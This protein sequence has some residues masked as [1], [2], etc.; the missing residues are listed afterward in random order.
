MKILV[1]EDDPMVAHINIKFANKAGYNDVESVADIE[2]AKKRLSMGDIDLVLLDIYFPVGKGTEILIW[3]RNNRLNTDVILITADR[4][5][6]T[7]EIAM[8]YGAVDYLI[9]PFDFE[10]FKAAMDKYI[11]K[12]NGIS[13]KINVEQNDIDAL[14]QDNTKKEI[15]TLAGDFLEKGMSE[16]TYTTIYKA[17][18]KSENAVTSEELGD[19]LGI[20]RVSVRRYLEFMESKG[21]LELKLIY[22]KKGRPQHLF[23]YIEKSN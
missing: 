15:L 19:M 6:E 9:K 22:G 1:I 13:G 14:F 16:K 11:R 7:V 4:S 20:S 17:M 18:Q 8:N 5:A 12:I 2:S 23:K 3:I 10:R 21:I